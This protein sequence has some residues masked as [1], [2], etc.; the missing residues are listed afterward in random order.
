MTL[1]AV[2]GQVKWQLLRHSL[3]LL[4]SHPGIV[5]PQEPEWRPAGGRQGA[6]RRICLNHGA[7]FTVT[8][9]RVSL[10]TCVKLERKSNLSCEIIVPGFFFFL[11]TIQLIILP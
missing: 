6:K 1:I 5:P 9:L 8:C 10:I 3:S 2:G 7:T 11:F 4:L